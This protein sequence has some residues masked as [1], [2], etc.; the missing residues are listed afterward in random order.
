[1]IRFYIALWAAKL[2]DAILTLRGDRQND[3][4]G[5]IA[6]RLCPDFM[7]RVRDCGEGGGRSVFEQRL[8]DGANAHFML[9]R[10]KENQV[11]GASAVAIAVISIS[12]AN[13]GAT[14]AS[15]ARALA[16]DYYNIYYVDLDTEQ[17]IEY[18]S[19]VG[20]QELSVERHGRDFFTEARDVASV[21]IHDQ[22]VGAFLERF[23][24]ENVVRELDESGAFLATY[25]LSDNGIYMA[26][27]MKISRMEP[28][29]HHIIIGI[30][31]KDASSA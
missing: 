9:R 31:V 24:K 8:H 13:E 7:A 16:A 18:S 5:Y 19:P 22:D 3:R 12:S 2:V 27:T 29:A 15:I 4:A 25:R 21:R 23:T 20:G 1:M 6:N 14:Y 10:I 28:D 11:T 26:T 17:F 30:S